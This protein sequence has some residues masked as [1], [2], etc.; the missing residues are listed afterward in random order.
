[1][2][3][4]EKALYSALSGDATLT[5]LLSSATAI[6]QGVAPD[7]ADPPYVVY[8]KQANTKTYTFGAKAWDNSLYLIKA[9]DER[10]SAARAGTIQDRL[11]VL[12]T[13]AALTVTGRT[14]LYLRPE[15]DVDYPEVDQGR[16]TW[17]RGHLYRIYTS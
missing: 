5:G 10:P 3:A 12:L 14:H 6:Y 16:T 8:G 13:D 17:H 4:L 15:T 1:M 7:G 9:V 2:N 11:E